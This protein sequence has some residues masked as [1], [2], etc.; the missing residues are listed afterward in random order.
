[1]LI[2]DSG[3]RP[4]QRQNLSALGRRPRFPPFYA[5]AYVR[6]KHY[7]CRRERST[8]VCAAE[9]KPT[10]NEPDFSVSAMVPPP[11]GVHP[12]GNQTHHGRTPLAAVVG[13]RNPRT[14]FVAVGR[15]HPACAH[16]S[17][18]QSIS[19]GGVELRALR[20]AE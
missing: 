9:P 17:L 16:P 18:R 5:C 3:R 4:D 8:R 11:A 14:D 20:I 2:R 10:T 12:S 7:K 15:I 13:L 19:L 1:M 6:P